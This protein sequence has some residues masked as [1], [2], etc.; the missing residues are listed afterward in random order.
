MFHGKTSSNWVDLV[1]KR[2]VR[3]LHNDFNIC[4]LKYFLQEEMN[5]VHT[6]NLQKLVLQ[7]YKCLSAENPSFVWKFFEKRDMK[8]EQ[9]Q[10][11]LTL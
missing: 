11:E 6:K 2:A 1:Q 3:I 7:I 9:T 8:Y 10:L 4:H 5:E